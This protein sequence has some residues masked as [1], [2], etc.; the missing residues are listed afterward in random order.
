MFVRVAIQI[1]SAKTFLYAVPGTFAP[2]VAVGK[3]VVCPFGK[4]RVTGF[5]VAVMP[6]AVCDRDVRE[7]LD[8]PDPEPLFDEED[9]AFYKWIAGYYLY[10]PGKV[11]G[12]ILPGGID[13]KSDRWFRLAETPPA[14]DRHLSFTQ[15]ELLKLL[16]PCPQGLSL[17]RLRRA[18]GKNDLYADI[19]RLE[20]AGLVVSE[21]RLNR[22]AVRVKKERW[23]GL[24]SAVP[25]EMR[26][27]TKQ[28][29]LVALLRERGDAPVRNLKALFS[30]AADFLRSLK[31]KD[32][33][34][35][36]EKEV[37]RGPGSPPKIGGNGNGIVL[38]AAQ[39]AVLGDIRECISARRFSPCL[40]HGVT[41]SGKTEI[42]LQA[43]AE[44][45]KG[46]GGAIYL[47]PEIALTA[48]LLARICGR[49][50]E[51]EIAV[52]HSG[53]SRSAR[54]DQ[55]K[56]IRRGEVRVVVGARSALF[57]PV[58][59]L[60]LVIVDEEHDPSY[61]QDDRL[62]YNARDLALVR[63][64]LSQATVLLGSA[65]PAIQTYFH[66]AEGR[67]RLL[68]L[69][70]RIDD[71]PLPRVEVVD[72]RTARDEQGRTPLLSRPLVAAIRETLADGKQTLLFLNRRGFHTFLL[73][74]D[75][76]HVFACPNCEIALTHHAAAGVLKCHH[77]DFAAKAAPLCPKCLGQ[78]VRSYGAGTERVEEEAK[79][80]FPE[81]RIARMD[82]DT[83]SRKGDAERILRGLDRREIDILVGTQM[84]TK[85]HDFPEITLVG[86]VAADASL[87][88]PDFRAAER[89]FQILTQVSGRGGRGDQPGRVVIQTFNPGHYAIVRAQ[90]HDYEGFYSDEIPLRRE[91]GYPPFSRLIGIHFSSL[92]KEGK[93]AVREIGREARDLTEALAGGKADVI[94][95]AESPLARLRGRY[96]WQ[97]LLRGKESGP[98]HLLAQKLLERAERDGLEIQ[99]DVDPVNFM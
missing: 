91:L 71:R 45:L 42:Y 29:A 51:R 83:T 69:P 82:S 96:R 94:G 68:N 21:E 76:G 32:V 89:T 17:N 54:Y 99:V 98:L 97:L 95:P 14:T 4:R 75:C 59:N 88:I 41:G 8:L 31:E 81:A 13:V 49:F 7:I 55:W 57:A 37:F 61:K 23:A 22:P 66:A 12:E 74:P 90:N 6:E 40:L 20:A 70:A 18:S 19:R 33:I 46:E 86:V 15:Q 87:N 64:R 80:L 78:R 2:F 56:R 39:T 85:G 50:P 34:R 47:V 16:A 65:T 48:Q 27:T 3:R 38:N 93:Q 63:G 62:R 36:Y 73:C 26:L 43:I 72:L 11:L 28:A 53:I 67:Y 25:P 24:T 1:P 44:V 5:I 52:L 30:N 77:C 79:R 10:P 60:R 35:L 84:I 58:R 92:K 9:L